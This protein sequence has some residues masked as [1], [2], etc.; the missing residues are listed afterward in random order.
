MGGDR[1]VTDSQ[2]GGEKDAGRSA[3]SDRTLL[4]CADPS[5]LSA[6]MAAL[7]DA[8]FRIVRAEG[9]AEALAVFEELR[10]PAV[11]IDGAFLEG[12][13]PRLCA[14]LRRMSGRIEVPILALCDGKRDVGRALEAGASD[15]VERPLDWSVV[16]RRLLSLYRGYSA[17]A[18]AARLR[19]VIQA[20]ARAEA[21]AREQ[22]VRQG[23]VDPLTG[24]QTRLALYQ[25]LLRALA[26]ARNLEI[27]VG[28]L[29]IDLDR[30]AVLNKTL[31][32]EEGDRVLIQVAA[33]LRNALSTLR[34][35]PGQAPGLMM[36]ARIGGNEFALMVTGS[37]ESNALA[38]FART[39]LDSIAGPLVVGGTEIR[40]RASVGIA[41][42][43]GG[44]TAPGD[45][46]Q[47]A[48]TA[49]Y[50]AKRQGGGQVVSY[51]S[52]IRGDADHR[53]GMD[54]RLR[55]AFE[56]ERLF[57]HYQPVIEQATRRVLGV[58]ALLRWED[59]ENGRVPPSEFVPIA[60]EM[61]FM[62]PLGT[63]VLEQAC[64]QLKVWRGAGLPPF[65]MAVN[66]SRR[67]LERD[68]LASV[69][70]RVLSE[71]GLDAG[72]LELEISEGR[73]LH[74]DPGI[75]ARLRSLKA[76]GVRIVVDD[77][78]T[79]PSSIASLRRF[80]IDTL[81]ID[82]SLIAGAEDGEDEAAVVSATVAAARRLGLGVVAVGVETRGQLA[83]AAELG[84]DAFQGFHFSQPLPPAEF[85]AALRIDERAVPR[86]E[87]TGADDVAVVS[88]STRTRRN[89][90]KVGGSSDV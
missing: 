61:G 10:P 8:G 6:G 42:A 66:V 12:S 63:W 77:F 11:L 5:V 33:R 21:E 59:G 67:Q 44:L 54:R 64:R 60:E 38:P 27:G 51:S 56:S 17:R 80:P 1:D 89:T 57:L 62:V 47:H 24:L 68:D 13:G 53:L 52:S 79:G 7:S 58:E 15:V 84:C 88:S 39:L 75:V 28:L 3:E 83:C 40:L 46:L 30:F 31:G 20:S 18:D 76:F 81:K 26:R 65:R 90:G 69:V 14:L 55:E 43:D 73:A 48:E 25:A 19:L 72:L 45:L 41:A 49:L 29:T 50:E 86:W 9:W 4:V 71:S 74:G 2:A 22:S 23:L 78:G 16:C 37:I 87:T 36:V 34:V 35:G 70:E 82:R 32:R 85:A